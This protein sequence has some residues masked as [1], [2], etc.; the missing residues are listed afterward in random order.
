MGAN[1]WRLFWGWN[2]LAFIIGFFAGLLILIS[3]ES[4]SD[5]FYESLKNLADNPI[6]KTLAA[7]ILL[8]LSVVVAALSALTAHRR[9]TDKALA[10]NTLD[11]LNLRFTQPHILDALK[12]VGSKYRALRASGTYEL[13]SDLFEALSD[14]LELLRNSSKEEDKQEWAKATM[15]FNYFEH[16][17]LGIQRGVYDADLIR[18][19]FGTGIINLTV[20]CGPYIRKRNAYYYSNFSEA[21]FDGAVR[22][23]DLE[24]FVQHGFPPFENLERQGQEWKQQMEYC[25]KDRV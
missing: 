4:I 6:V 7:P 12:I 14:W 13:N 19:T 16:L 11:A 22:S 18:S 8:F 24:K 25:F 21:L 17:C 2:L 23:P 9:D 15:S 5:T 3:G 10:K 20:L 1:G